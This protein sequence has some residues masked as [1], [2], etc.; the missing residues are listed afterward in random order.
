MKVKVIV[1]LQNRRNNRIRVRW[2]RLNNWAQFL[3]YYSITDLCI[4][5]NASLSVNIIYFTCWM[6]MN[7]NIDK[8]RRVEN[9]HLIIS[10]MRL[11]RIYP[12]SYAYTVDWS[13]TNTIW[14]VLKFAHSGERNLPERTK[15][16]GGIILNYFSILFK[17]E[18]QTENGSLSGSTRIRGSRV[19]QDAAGPLIVGKVSTSAP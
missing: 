9:W 18:Q 17:R 19:R 12:L 10:V 8:K 5:Y 16:R 2:A 3:V 1:N 14:S 6:K 13:R 4:K 15:G 7:E 11:W